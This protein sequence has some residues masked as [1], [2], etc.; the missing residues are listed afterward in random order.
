M[1]S[2]LNSVKSYITDV[3]FLSNYTLNSILEQHLVVGLCRSSPPLTA[4]RFMSE[5]GS[6]L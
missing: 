1:E 2:H 5:G 4:S 6:V 3:L